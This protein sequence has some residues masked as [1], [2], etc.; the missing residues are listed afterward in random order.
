MSTLRAAIAALLTIPALSILDAA[1]IQLPDFRMAA[2]IAHFDVTC[3]PEFDAAAAVI[4]RRA[5]V[6]Y[7]RV[8]SMLRHDLSFRPLL[9]LFAT[10]A[11]QMRA[12]DTRTIPGNREHVLLTLD[13]PDARLDGQLVHDLS[14][15]FLFDALA[16]GR[17]HDVPVWVLEGLAEHQRGE[18]DA[19]DLAMLKSLVGSGTLPPLSAIE[20]GQ[21][22]NQNGAVFGHAAFDFLTLRAG[23]DGLRL[24]FEAL[25]ANPAGNPTAAYIATVGLSGADFDRAFA[26]YL[27][28]RL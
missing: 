12:I 2:Q 5:E 11:D 9:V 24:F 15:V 4:G 21:V 8:S 22:E 27:K 28:A 26:A 10:R 20:L 16:P 17:H 7:Q 18:W 25:R 13:T 1:P 14:H 6:A 3:P 23:S 19:N